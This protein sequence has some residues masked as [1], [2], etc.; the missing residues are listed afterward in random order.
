[1]S[2]L[3]QRADQTLQP[4]AT[5][6][7]GDTMLRRIRSEFLEMPGLCLTIRQA[8]RLWN[9]EPAACRVMLEQL[10]ADHLL[11]RTLDG[12]YAVAEWNTA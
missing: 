10:V 4:E 8:A 1:M 11:T 9:L 3:E 5:C 7:S 6:R 12:R 2:A